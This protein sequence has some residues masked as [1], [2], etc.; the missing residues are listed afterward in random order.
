[1]IDLL[2]PVL[3]RPER[4]LPLLSSIRAATISPGYTVN[5]VV[6]EDDVDEVAMIEDVSSM[7]FGP[8]DLN[9]VVRI[10]TVEKRDSGDYAGKI[11]DSFHHTSWPEANPFVLLGADD[12]HFHPR[13]DIEVLDV[14]SQDES[15]LV[16]GTNDLGNKTVMAGR[17]STHP[18]LSREYV[19]VHG[20]SWD[21][22]G[23]VYHEGYD[24]Q[25][26]DTELIELAVQR[27]CFR[28]AKD[29]HVE[30]LHP[31]WG[32]G[33]MDAVYRKGQRA[34]QADAKLFQQRKR[35]YS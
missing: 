15:A 30:H 2:I 18:V 23:V 24:H 19:M 8:P 21:G 9:E 26:C 28:F 29:A 27:D 16:V 14:F 10:I 3:N 35:A 1:M 34:S 31:F 25:Y 12:L 22:P 4:V 33:E 7:L 32:K 5:F 17:H 13:W 11:N 20:A 6:T